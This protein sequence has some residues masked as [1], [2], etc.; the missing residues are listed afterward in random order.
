M[1]KLPLLRSNF[2]SNSMALLTVIRLRMV[3]G[4]ND[5]QCN[6][7]TSCLALRARSMLTDE[8]VYTLVKLL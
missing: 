8:P 4:F 6:E 1:S 3:L 2:F 5:A 7:M